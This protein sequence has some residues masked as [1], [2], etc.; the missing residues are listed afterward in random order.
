MDVSL[1]PGRYV[2]A[3][4]GGVDS[5]V[6]LEELQKLS[7]V[8]LIVAHYDHGIRPDSGMDRQLVEQTAKR[9]GL[10][11]EYMEGRLDA[12]VGE[13]E[14][15]ASRYDFLRQVQ[16]FHKAEAIITAHHQDDVLE[17]AIINILRGTG[18]KGLSALGSDKNIVRPLLRTTKRE[19]REYAAAHPQIVWREDSTNNNEKYLRNYIR[20][21][22]MKGLGEHGRE[23]LL[24]YVNRAAESNPLIDV[25]L[26]H[27]IESQSKDGALNRRWFTML[28]HDVACEVLAAWLRS[29]Q[30]RD[31]NKRTIERLVIGLK[32]FPA[33]KVLDVNTGYSLEVGKTTFRLIS[34][35]LSSKKIISV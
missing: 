21:H 26:L 16:E 6:L 24:Q 8:E 30:I 23:Q 1:D 10:P 2:V 25:I 33:G 31:F 3:V 9:Y 22:I 28:P 29:R 18:R 13:A 4:S 32:V 12:N 14:A 35:S 15:R 5:M 7:G 34:G 11:F 17:T 20:R 19:I 27:E